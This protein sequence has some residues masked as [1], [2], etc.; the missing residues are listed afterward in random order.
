MSLMLAQVTVEAAGH[1][2]FYGALAGSAAALFGISAAFLASRL[3]AVGERVATLNRERGDLLNDLQ[4]PSGLMRDWQIRSRRHEL[5]DLHPLAGQLR[6]AIGWSVG[7]AVVLVTMSLA[8]LADIGVPDARWYRLLLLVAF[9]VAVVG[10]LRLLLRMSDDLLAVTRVEYELRRRQQKEATARGEP[11]IVSGDPDQLH[12][13]ASPDTLMEFLGQVAKA[14]G[15]DPPKLSRY[16]MM[17]A[18]RRHRRNRR[19]PAV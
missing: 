5:A 6:Q 3:V 7:A 8:P 10:W 17:R 13:N 19:M 2:A 9:V 14:K 15:M 4:P 1:E 16:R 12:A 11:F 18:R